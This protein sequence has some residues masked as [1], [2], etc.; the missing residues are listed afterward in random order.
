MTGPY[1]TLVH[2]LGIRQITA[3]TAYSVATVPYYRDDSCFDDGTGSDP[4]PHLQPASVDPDVDSDGQPRVCWDP[5]MG[6][7]ASV[8]PRDHLY[9]GDIGT[10]GVHIQLIADSDNAAGTVPSTE[11]DSEAR[12]V[13]LPGLQPNVGERYGRGT[14]KPLVVVVL[15]AM[16]PVL[17]RTGRARNPRRLIPPSRGFFANTDTTLSSGQPI[18]LAMDRTSVVKQMYQ[19][20]L[21]AHDLLV[22]G[23]K[24]SDI[25]ELAAFSA[26][27][28]EDTVFYFQSLQLEL[29]GREA[30]EQ[31]MVEARQTV[32]VRETSERVFEHGNLVV[33]LNRSSLTGS[34][35]DASFPVVAVFQFDGDRVSGFWGFAG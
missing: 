21:D 10:H 30:I 16:T 15:P 32:G 7:P 33:S 13:V 8:V 5:S 34:E 22:A 1:G 6:D 12:I 28:D 29:R 25:P 17:D 31:F 35:G 24:P 3:G 11:I 18:D 4:G 9:Q 27:M 20:Y 26:R 23:T 2:R 19:G 14:E